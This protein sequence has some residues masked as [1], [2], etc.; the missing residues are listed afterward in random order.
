[1]PLINDD[2]R[3]H[4]ISDTMRIFIVACKRSAFSHRNDRVPRCRCARIISLI[5]TIIFRIFIFLVNMKISNDEKD[6][7][8]D[9]IEMGR[10]T[11][12]KL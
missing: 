7:S 1:M 12:R 5:V 11:A 9:I 2:N 3:M 6:N 10:F 4:Y 8:K